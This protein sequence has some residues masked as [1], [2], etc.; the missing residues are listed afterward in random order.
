[1]V[2]LI[3]STFSSSEQSCSAFDTGNRVRKS[4]TLKSVQICRLKNR[5]FQNDAFQGSTPAQGHIHLAVSKGPSPYVHD[6]FVEGL[7][8]AFMDG[9]SPCQHQ[10]VLGEG[11]YYLGL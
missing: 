1:M 9:N 5:P 8:L 10:R 11:A 4:T 6:H 7:T 3:I 2:F